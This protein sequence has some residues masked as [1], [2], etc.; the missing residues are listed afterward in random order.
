[1]KKLVILTIF[2]LFCSQYINAQPIFSERGYPEH[3][4]AGTLIGGGVSYLVFKKT[5]N[6]FKAW[7]LGTIAAAAVGFIKEAVDPDLLSGVRSTTDAVYTSFGGAFGASIVIPLK[8]KKTKEKPNIAAAF[9]S[10]PTQK[11]KSYVL[12]H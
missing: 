9:R 10:S 11:T 8:R 2:V 12:V 4:I 7:A 5:D 1:M 3:F 6:K